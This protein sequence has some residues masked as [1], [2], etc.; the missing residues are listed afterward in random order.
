MF[1]GNSYHEVTQKALHSAN[2]DPVK[3][4]VFCIFGHYLGSEVY[5]GKRTTEFCEQDLL[6]IHS[7]RYFL[8]AC[9]VPC[10]RD[11]VVIKTNESICF[12]GT[13]EF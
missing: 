7:K 3:Q 10:A 6:F 9:Q 12:H 5:M 11:I 2:N 4:F 8:K 13:Y 1:P